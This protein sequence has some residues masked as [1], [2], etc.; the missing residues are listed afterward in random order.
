MDRICVIA[1][2]ESSARSL[3]TRLA[4]FFVARFFHLD[5]L[6]DAAPE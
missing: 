5:L 4:G 2:N 3:R 6:P 1:E